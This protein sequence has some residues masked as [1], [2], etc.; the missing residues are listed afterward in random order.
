[1]RGWGVIPEA[2]SMNGFESVFNNQEKSAK[3]AI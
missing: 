3:N 1:V 2:Y